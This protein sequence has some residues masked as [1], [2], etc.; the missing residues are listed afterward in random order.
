MREKVSLDSAK[1]S[2]QVVLFFFYK[3]RFS[4]E[5]ARHFKDNLPRADLCVNANGLVIEIKCSSLLCM[6]GSV[7]RPDEMQSIN[8]S[9]KF[10][11]IMRYNDL[12]GNI[13]LKSFPV[14]STISH[15]M[16]H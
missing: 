15:D 10:R 2:Y 4:T 16:Y 7:L 6:V 12:F 11:N 1:L 5:I 3:A 14:C 13:R 8:L 9:M